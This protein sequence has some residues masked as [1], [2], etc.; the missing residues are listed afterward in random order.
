MITL[1]ASAAI[2]VV[3]QSSKGQQIEKLII[4]SECVIAPELFLAE[5]GNAFWKYCQFDN[6]TLEL[7]KKALDKAI[8]LV[9][10]FIPSQELIKE[11][12]SLSCSVNCSVYDALYLVLTRRNSG[13]LVTLDQKLKIIASRQNIPFAEMLK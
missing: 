11:A 4:E 8:E 13:M 1:D 5:V 9:D 3:N 12:F 6:L 2:N 7:G 10:V